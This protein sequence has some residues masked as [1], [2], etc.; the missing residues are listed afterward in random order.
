MT[1]FVIAP[2]VRASQRGVGNGKNSKR[3]DRGHDERRT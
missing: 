2:V 3:R 1:G